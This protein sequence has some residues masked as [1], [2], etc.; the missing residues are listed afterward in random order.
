MGSHLPVGT[1]AGLKIIALLAISLALV[2]STPLESSDLLDNVVPSNQVEENMM[3]E[4]SLV[5]ALSQAAD[6]NMHNWFAEY[7]QLMKDYKAEFDADLA[8]SNPE[9]LQAKLDIIKLAVAKVRDGW[10][11]KQTQL[12]AIQ[13]ILDD[14]RFAG[15]TGLKDT[16]QQYIDAEMAQ[17]KE[18]DTTIAAEEADVVAEQARLDNHPCDCVHSDWSEYG[19]CMVSESIVTCYDTVKEIS[20]TQTRTRKIERPPRND[21]AACEALEEKISCDDKKGKPPLDKCPIDCVWSD[22]GPFGECDKTCGAG[23]RHSKREYT[24]PF[25]GGAECVGDAT[26]KQPCNLMEELKKELENCQSEKK[27]LKQQVNCEPSKCKITVFQDVDVGCHGYLPDGVGDTKCG[28]KACPV[29]SGM[30]S[31]DFSEVCLSGKAIDIEGGCHAYLAKD[32][33]EYSMVFQPGFNSLVGVSEHDAKSGVDTAL[34]GNFNKAKLYC[35]LATPSTVSPTIKKIAEKS[36]KQEQVS[37]GNH[38]AD[39]CEKCPQGNGKSWCNG[40]CKW[41]SQGKCT[42][43]TI[44]CDAGGKCESAIAKRLKR[45]VSEGFPDGGKSDLQW[46]SQLLHC[47]RARLLWGGDSKAACLPCICDYVQANTDPDKWDQF[48]DNFCSKYA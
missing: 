8:C 48:T 30:G 32:D 7:A 19:P 22:W 26:Q 36:K 23:F 11:A 15:I 27:R 35:K 46:G 1:M 39:S 20:G 42:D 47:T 29:V 24:G 18:E 38:K 41:T 43:K 9:Y 17:L 5:R 3:R 10:T 6:R 25:Y 34:M 13:A 4:V 45:C 33:H 44:N 21:G 37:C 2:S 31:P 40:D 12:A 28:T 14:E 16:L